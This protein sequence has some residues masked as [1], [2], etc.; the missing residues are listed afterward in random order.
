MKKKAL[1]GKAL[2]FA[3][4][5]LLV[6]SIA[7][8]N[9]FT[10]SDDDG[11]PT[12]TEPPHDEEDDDSHDI[13]EHR[14]ETG[15]AWI[16][17]DI[18][19]VMLNSELPSYQYWFTPDENGSLARFMINFM[20][21]VEFEDH[22]EDGVFQPNETLKF[23]PLDA[24]EWILKTGA[25]TKE[26]GST[27]EVYASYTK[28]GLSNDWEDDWFEEWMPEWE[29]EDPPEDPPI[30]VPYLLASGDFENHTFAHFAELTLQFYGH[31]YS[32]DYNGTVATEEGVHAEYTVEGG[33]ELKVDIEIGNFPFTS[34]TSKVAILNYL[35]E[36]VASSEDVNHYFTLHEESGEDDH[37][38]E[39]EMEFLGEE[40]EDVLDED[41][42]EISFV[43]ES[44]DETQGFYR[45]VDK[46]LVKNLEGVKEPVDV[47][48]SYWTDGEGLLLF[49]SYP[50]FNGGSLIH[51]P[52]VR[53]VENASPYV[54]PPPLDIPVMTVAVGSSIVILAAV[55]L[56]LKR[57]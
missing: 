3:M 23:A 2:L 32:D 5:F 1:F 45:W 21:I 37:E 35:R 25:I 27:K 46:A 54:P 15:T 31:I 17:T 7:S 11:T 19:T 39:V 4:L 30:E 38:S 28:G 6:S 18:V 24:F 47:Q 49:L 20:M 48:A 8:V 10:T 56:T 41:V 9:A 50:N 57:R 16:E 26:D 40:F 51:D 52:S 13:D 42:Q 33:S 22:N 12:E 36:D 53:L 29:E 34:E 55:G 14:D 44:S 43:D